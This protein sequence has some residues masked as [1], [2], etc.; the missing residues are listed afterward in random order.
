MSLEKVI[1]SLKFLE[2][3]P[4]IESYKWRFMIQKITFLAQALGMR[5][6]YYFTIY[7][8][9]PYSPVLAS[10]YYRNSNRV[11]SLETDYD[12]APEE[13]QILQKIRSCDNLSDNPSLIECTSTIVYLMKENPEMMDH[14][15]LTRTRELKPYLNEYTC[16]TGLSKAKE[17]LF[18]PEYLTEDLKQE[19]A[20]WDRIE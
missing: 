11:N 20:E 19:I 10:D 7:V 9:G 13:I 1:A 5:T 15:V 17:L 12:L 3:Q 14:T 2:L 6:N 16:V 18:K 4:N 8:A